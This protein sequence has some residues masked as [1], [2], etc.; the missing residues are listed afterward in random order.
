M[1]ELVDRAFALAD[2]ELAWDGNS[3]IPPLVRA[4]A[5]TGEPAVVVDPALVRASDPAGIGGN[6]TRA[7]AEL[8]WQARPGLDVFLTDMLEADA[9][10]AISS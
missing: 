8:G 1:W 7:L 4:I 2:L 9:P 5:A 10:A 3:T 6:P